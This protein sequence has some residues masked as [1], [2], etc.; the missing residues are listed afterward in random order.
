M[1][2]MK[3]SFSDLRGIIVLQLARLVWVGG[4]ACMGNLSPVAYCKFGAQVECLSSYFT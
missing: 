3:V 1:S 4:S 2:F